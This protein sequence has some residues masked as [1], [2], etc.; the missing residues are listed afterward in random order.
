MP[1]KSLT[2]FT[3]DQLTG[4]VAWYKADALSLNDGDAVATWTDSSGNSNDATQGTG[5]AQPTFKT[6][7]INGKPV[8]RFDGGDDLSTAT[9]SNFDLATYS[10]FFVATRSAGTTLISKN[11]TGTGA[12]GRRKLQIGL[13]GNISLSAGSDGSAINNTATVT[14]PGVYGVIARANNDH[15]LI[16]NGTVNNKTTTL[17]DTTFNNSAFQIG[18]A[19]SNGSER[20]TGDIAEIIIFNRAVSSS[21]SLG[22]QN[23]LAVKYNVINDVLGGYPR[24]AVSNRIVLPA[25][26]GY[27]LNFDGTND[28][29]TF[30]NNTSHNSLTGTW[31][32]WVKLMANKS[33]NG[34]SVMSKNDGGSSASGINIYLTTNNI[35]NGQIKSGITSR[36]DV[37]GTI[38]LSLYKWYHY[39]LTFVNN[40]TVISYING[41]Q[42]Y[43]GSMSG[44][45][46]FNGQSLLLGENADSYWADFNGRLKYVRIFNTNLN[47]TQVANLYR[48]I[49]DPTNLVSEYFFNEGSGTTITDNKGVQN[50]TITSATY[51]TDVPFG[52]RTAL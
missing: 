3:P 38:P 46:A 50:G 10:V 20:I 42:D 2:Y 48:N 31:S 5:S 49:I 16:V 39:A 18:A 43:S 15:D 28:R 7:I 23:Y 47:A 17:D 11:T 33:G 22:I 25:T 30:S 40:G 19:F 44:S 45:F 9:E 21:E 51:S 41:V 36:C 32:F 14:T 6:S 52:A 4:L 1:R 26:S 24:T 12:G 8:V 35:M 13:A 27:S 37:S 29:V 34:N